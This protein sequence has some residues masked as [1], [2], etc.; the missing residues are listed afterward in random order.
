MAVVGLVF[1]LDFGGSATWYVKLISR[2][3]QPAERVLR[4][5]PPWRRILRTPIETRL[6]WEV[7]FFRVAGAVLVASGIGAIVAGLA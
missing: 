3:M 6:R 5:V 4:H 2:L 1:V 7:V